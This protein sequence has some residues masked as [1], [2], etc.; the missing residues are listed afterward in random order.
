MVEIVAA[1][2]DS[3]A[4]ECDRLWETEM[5]RA[6]WLCRKSK[7]TARKE[8]LDTTRRWT[9]VESVLGLTAG[10][11]CVVCVGACALECEEEG[12]SEKPRKR[13][14][15]G[16]SHESVECGPSSLGLR[17]QIWAE[18]GDRLRRTQVC[19]RVMKADEQ[20]LAEE[21]RRGDSA[22]ESSG[23]RVTGAAV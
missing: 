5:S 3:D 15:G 8:W 17:L 21:G 4:H 18:P 22:L 9:N 16:L 23:I 6:S 7:R 2:S 1:A 12:R 10:G 13:L 20:G 11:E 19:V 14:R